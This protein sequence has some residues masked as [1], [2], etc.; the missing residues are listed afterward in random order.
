[1]YQKAF[2]GKKALNSYP[3]RIPS[4]HAAPA[5]LHFIPQWLDA[6]P[7]Y[8]LS[9][10]NIQ[11]L[12]IC[13]KDLFCL[14]KFPNLGVVLMRHTYEA[15]DDS[16]CDKDMRNWGREVQR[17]EAFKNLKVVAFHH[18]I[19][20][21]VSTLKCFAKFP[22]L[23]ICS[24]EPYRQLSSMGH[25]ADDIWRASL[26]FSLAPKAIAD[27]TADIWSGPPTS[28]LAKMK[29]LYDLAEKWQPEAHRPSIAK[30]PDPAIFSV[31]YG[32]ERS[33]SYS[34]FPIW[35]IRDWLSS[36]YKPEEQAKRAGEGEGNES[37]KR[38]I[39]T[40]KQSNIGSFLETFN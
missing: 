34:A 17:M 36:R 30:E 4:Y 39:R 37:K 6:L 11:G 12:R 27:Q 9:F 22:A 14:L 1:M 10:L 23:S 5:E 28:S 21:L 19:P 18:F 38:K 20:S 40:G 7:F 2:P 32:S 31:H 29:L 24:V 3:I 35:F 26:P 33:F 13:L 16:L 15:K 25:A 8:H